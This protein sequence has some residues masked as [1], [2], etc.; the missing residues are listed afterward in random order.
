MKCLSAVGAGALDPHFEICLHFLLKEA[1]Q[2][3]TN[4]F[5]LIR[6]VRWK[7]F[8]EFA[9]VFRR[10]QTFHSPHLYR[11]TFNKVFVLRDFVCVRVNT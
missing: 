6:C 9:N 7:I 2:S 4:S 8:S 5:N 1:V 3:K 11:Q 10:N